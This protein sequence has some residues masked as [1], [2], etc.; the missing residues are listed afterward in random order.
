[1]APRGRDWGG[2]PLGAVTSGTTGHGKRGRQAKMGWR[3]HAQT[4]SRQTLTPGRVL[5]MQG[6]PGDQAPASR[7]PA[8]AGCI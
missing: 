2:A 1:M 6:S 4:A 5:I 3:R 8:P 7:S